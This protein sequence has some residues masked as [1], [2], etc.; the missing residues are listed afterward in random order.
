LPF[1]ARFYDLGVINKAR[2]REL[3]SQRR[4]LAQAAKA[5]MLDVIR[6]DRQLTPEEQVQLDELKEQDDGLEREVQAILDDV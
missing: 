4:A 1:R 3:E 5:L 2:V 6:S